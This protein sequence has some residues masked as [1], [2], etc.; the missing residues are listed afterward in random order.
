MATLDTSENMKCI[1]Q[2]KIEDD[3]LSILNSTLKT[4]NMHPIDAILFM[5]KLINWSV[6]VHSAIGTDV[7]NGLIIGDK[8]FIEDIIKKINVDIKGS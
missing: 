5:A 7:I 3:K 4:L 6:A 1:E 2:L 8:F